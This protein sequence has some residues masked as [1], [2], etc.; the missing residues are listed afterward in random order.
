MKSIFITGGTSGIGE[1]LAKDFYD[2]GY[3]VGI[4]ARSKSKF[5]ER[6]KDYKINFYQADI[7]NFE[8]LQIAIDDFAK[9]G[10][11]IIVA[12]AGK[13]YQSKSSIPDF[14]DCKE[15]VTINV[16]GV[17]NT[18][19]IAT[20]HFLENKGGQLVAM[21]S[22]AG[23]NGLPGVPAYSA[24][25]SAVIKYCESL[26]LSLVKNK[27]FVT[28]ICP[29]FIRTPLTDRNKH[30]MPFLTDVSEASKHFL[31]AIESKKRLY[32]YPRL[33]GHIVYCLGCLPRFIFRMIIKRSKLN[34][35]KTQ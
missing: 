33:F 19:E 31:K 1:Q 18:F 21:S 17:I 10:L 6:F 4:C 8:E 25:K 14:K 11:D 29:G 7:T 15:I 27:I 22:I 34:Y 32:I 35:T 12:N 2:K 30:P 13:G 20:K 23:F 28:C 26:S 16:L 9:H 3:R 5:D 24:S